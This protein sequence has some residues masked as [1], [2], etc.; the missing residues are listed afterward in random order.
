MK[1]Y[2]LKMQC[3][4]CLWKYETKN[5]ITLFGA[6]IEAKRLKKNHICSN[7]IGAWRIKG[8]KPL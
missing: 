8:V 5:H 6:K 3:P 1:Q 7:A 4:K 2:K